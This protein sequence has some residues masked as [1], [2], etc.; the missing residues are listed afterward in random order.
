MSC[1]EA[2]DDRAS[3]GRSQRA[4]AESPD[5]EFTVAFQLLSLLQFV[6]IPAG[7]ISS[8]ASRHRHQISLTTRFASI[9]VDGIEPSN[10]DYLE[11]RMRETLKC[12]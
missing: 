8:M 7:G 5:N 10:S 6:E 2:R 12:I 3:S 1:E 4:S 11:G 9:V